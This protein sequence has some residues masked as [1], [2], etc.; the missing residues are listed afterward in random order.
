V[1]NR[2]EAKKSL[3]DAAAFVIT[4]SCRKYL[5]QQKIKRKERRPLTDDES[6]K[7]ES[8]FYKYLSNFRNVYRVIRSMYEADGIYEEMTRQFE[9]IND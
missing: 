4:H 8:S 3:K 2:L 6:F 5:L 7:M 9:F 1:L